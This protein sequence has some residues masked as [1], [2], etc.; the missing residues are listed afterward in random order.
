MGMEPVSEFPSCHFSK[1]LRK[2]KFTLATDSS[3]EASL[4]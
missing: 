1:N 3:L 2:E 4:N